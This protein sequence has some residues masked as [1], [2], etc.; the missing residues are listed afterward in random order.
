MFSKMIPEHS[1]GSLEDIRLKFLRQEGIRLLMLDFDNTI[2]A[3]TQHGEPYWF[4]RWLREMQEGRIIVCVVTNS[5]K[6]KAREFCRQWNIPVY[7]HARKPSP[8]KLESVRLRYNIPREQCAMVGDQIFTDILAANRAWMHSYL[9]RP[10]RNHN[11]FLKAR[12]SLQKLILK[13]AKRR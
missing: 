6:P 7:T 5:R 1:F 8:K 3:Y 10:I 12:Y 11:I 13:I 4:R 9:V 2:L